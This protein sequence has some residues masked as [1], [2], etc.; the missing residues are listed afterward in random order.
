VFIIAP[1]INVKS[2]SGKVDEIALI[3]IHLGINPVRG[4]IPASDSIRRGRDIWRYG[5]CIMTFLIFV[6]IDMDF[7]WKIMKIGAIIIEYMAK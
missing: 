1:A 3:V 7:N 4:G 5:D 6:L 2:N